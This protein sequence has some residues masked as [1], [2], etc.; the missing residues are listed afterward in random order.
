MEHSE[1][2]KEK[3]RVL[4]QTTAVGAPSARWVSGHL[5]ATAKGW[6]LQTPFTSEL[7]REK[8]TR[9][10]MFAHSERRREPGSP[11]AHTDESGVTGKKCIRRPRADHAREQTAK[12]RRTLRRRFRPSGK[13]RRQKVVGTNIPLLFRERE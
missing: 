9:C 2:F 11:P 4:H 3:G 5:S 8:G 1:E 10:L 12:F 7:T 6:R 13:G